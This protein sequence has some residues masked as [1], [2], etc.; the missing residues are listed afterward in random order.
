MTKIFCILDGIG[1]RPCKQLKQLTPLEAAKT[2]NLDFLS[3]K[4]NHGYVYTLGED[5]APES[6]E[7]ILALLG[8]DPKEYYYGRGPLE[9][10]GAG[11]KFKEG[12]LALRTNFSTIEKNSNKIIDRRAG[13]TLTTKEAQKLAK[14]INEEVELGYEFE[15][16]ATV[17]H[18]GVL[19]VKGDFSGNISNVDP[20]YKKVGKFGVAVHNKEMNIQECIALDPS[21]KSTESAK[22]VNKFVEQTR[23]IL[24]N[25]EVNRKR[26]KK[27]LLEAN[28]IIPRDAGTILPKLPKKKNWGAIVS[29]PLETGIAKLSSMEVLNFEYPETENDVYEQLYEG[30][31]KT[32][33]ESIK[34]ISLGKYEKY[35]V[36]FKETDIPGHDNKPLDKVKMIE[37]IDKKFFRFVKDIKDVELIVTGDHSSPCEIYGHSADH[38]PLLHLGKPKKDVVE[39]FT[40]QECLEGHYGRLYGKDVIKKLEFEK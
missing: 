14:T 23:Q 34:Q 33:K 36:H 2:P 1:D 30:L 40:E 5:I 31:N 21:K 22:I 13:R 17:G 10:Y 27:M 39:R 35:L 20:A 11:M 12:Y 7:A 9:A 32:I 24:K 16:K 18:R 6:D 28:I 8:Y 4:S 3:N 29:M 26:N 37:I 19:V 38:V 15:F 25:H